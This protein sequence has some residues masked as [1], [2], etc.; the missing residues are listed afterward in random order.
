MD[1]FTSLVHLNLS[2]PKN[3]VIFDEKVDQLVRQNPGL[4]KLILCGMNLSDAVLT[5]VT[6][7]HHLQHLKLSGSE[8]R[9]TVNGV[10]TLLSSRLR[11]LLL[12]GGFDVPETTDEEKKTIL[13]DMRLIAAERGKPLKWQDSGWGS[14]DG[15][16]FGF[17]LEN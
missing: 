6:R 16:F 2:L 5:S 13:A 14:G 7:L 12:F 10:L 15:G 3:D 4:R 1:N 17:E 8:V 11:T 9:F